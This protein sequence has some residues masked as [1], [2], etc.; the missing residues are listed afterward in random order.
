MQ[1]T[2][3]DAEPQ[4]TL[5]AA[6]A[7]WNGN[8]TTLAVN[9]QVQ[10][11]QTPDGTLVVGYWVTSGQNSAGQLQVSSGGTSYPPLTVPALLP[12]PQILMNN[13]Q[14]NNLKITNT[15][16]NGTTRIW[17][18]A[19]GPGIPGITPAPLTVGGPA[20]T[21]GTTSS[22][23]GVTLP[24]RM[25]L[26]ISAPSGFLGIFAIVGGPLDTTGNNGYVVAVNAAVTAGPGTSNPT[27]TPPAG[28][29]ATTTGN[30]YTFSFNWNGAL[31]YVVNMSA[32]SVSG[33]VLL[34]SV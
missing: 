18:S 17:V 23:Q 2:P 3:Y 5:N 22:A 7:D 11:P 25:Q 32:A 15:S 27:G 34:L 1:D 4:Q 31:I 28:Y 30:A 9:G 20:R 16:P 19:Y 21:L 29:Y 26:Q 6:A 12:Q 10:M 8:G 33:Q 24:A 14:A 13:W